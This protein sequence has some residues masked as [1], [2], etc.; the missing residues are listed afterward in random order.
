MQS[1]LLSPRQNIKREEPSGACALVQLP[2]ELLRLIIL[3]AADSPKDLCVLECVSTR[4]RREINAA[5]DEYLWREVSEK[6]R[7]RS[8]VMRHSR[9]ALS[10]GLSL[11]REL[12]KELENNCCSSKQ[13]SCCDYRRVRLAEYFQACVP[14]NLIHR[15]SFAMNDTGILRSYVADGTCR[16]AE[17]RKMLTA[18]VKGAELSRQEENN[19][20]VEMSLCRLS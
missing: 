10:R 11:M 16:P 8:V 9:T 14:P 1:G 12:P 3:W 4:F 7:R 18:L 5:A 19:D 2:S 6:W 17:V 20:I 15:A 13:K